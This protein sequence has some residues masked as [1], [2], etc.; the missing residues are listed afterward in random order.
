M[1]IEAAQTVSPMLALASPAEKK[2]GVS[3]TPSSSAATLTTQ[4]APALSK[5]CTIT[6]T[7]I[8]TVQWG[9]R[10]PAMA[11]M[12]PADADWT[13]SLAKSLYTNTSV[14][15]PAE[16][17][18]VSERQT[19]TCSAHLPVRHLLLFQIKRSRARQLSLYTNTSVTLPAEHAS[20]SERQ[21]L[22][23]SA[24][25]VSGTTTRTCTACLLYTSPSPRD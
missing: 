7:A 11:T 2:K 14:T 12:S 23:Y 3:V 9:V 21:T 22:T 13:F 24:Q 19:L 10:A 25:L 8:N 6:S 4:V 20:V 17:A 5:C 1:R 15:L 18:S 16:H